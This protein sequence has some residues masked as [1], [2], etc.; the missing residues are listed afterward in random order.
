MNKKPIIA[1]SIGDPNGIG[2]EIILKTLE[3]RDI[4][5]EATYVVFCPWKLWLFYKK[6]FNIGLFA[7]QISDFQD[8]VPDKVNVFD[9][10]CS[11]F[12]V[13][14][15]VDTI[16]AGK[17]AFSSL[18][19]ATQAVIDGHCDL[20][21]TAPINKSNIQ[22]EGFDFP[23]HT[24]YLEKKWGGHNLMFMV[25]EDIKVGL[26]TQHI[27][28]KEV[29]SALNQDIIAQK[30]R[31]IAG[32]LQRDFNVG[33]PIIAILGVNPHAG[34][35][36]LLG[37]EETEV[38]IPAIKKLLEEGHYA[39]G[40]YPADSY[41][42]AKNLQNVDAVLAMYHDQG[43]IPFKTIAG[44]RGVNYTAGLPFVRTSPD[45]GVGYDI[46]GKNVAD[47]GSFVEAVNTGIEIYHNRKL[48]ENL[49]KNA[50]S[51]KRR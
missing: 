31:L 49:E 30:Y 20:L 19:Y 22:S 5:K 3:R 44:I 7:K 50:L 36:G 21:V 47:D 4:Q 37:M 24:E 45:H 8:I 38:I 6:H 15:G 2:S 34:D 25:H 13:S 16:E 29:A 27:P 14:F 35:Q 51:T 46:A 32:S 12:F 28:L 18:E 40:P 33:K 41:F 10:V 9:S 1:I 11:D 17:V 42:S 43:L 23:G 39:Y 48:N 26:V